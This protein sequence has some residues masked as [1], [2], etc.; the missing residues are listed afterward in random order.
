MSIVLFINFY[1]EVENVLK[2]YVVMKK[3]NINFIIEV[4]KFKV[5]V[6]V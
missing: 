1:R 6:I 2:W 3:I 4:I 5:Y